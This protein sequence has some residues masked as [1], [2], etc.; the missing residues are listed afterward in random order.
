V[1]PDSVR[2][3]RSRIESGEPEWVKWI[4][5]EWEGF[6]D[7]ESVAFWAEVPIQ[8]V[9]AILLNLDKRGELTVDDT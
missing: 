4:K 8:A 9:V 7:M 3:L 1:D 5:K 6:R 2:A